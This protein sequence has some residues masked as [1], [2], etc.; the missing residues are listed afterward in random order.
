M[1]EVIPHA[2]GYRW[3]WIC[4]IGR[5]LVECFEVHPCDISAWNAAKNYRVNFWSIADT[6]DHRQGRCI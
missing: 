4:A 5:T 6:I 3:R 1:I 2:N